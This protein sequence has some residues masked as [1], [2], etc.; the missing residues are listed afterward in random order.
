MR[1]LL[2]GLMI[3]FMASQSAFSQ[4]R[5]LGSFDK[6]RV[7]GGIKVNLIKSSDTK[8]DID[9]E[10]GD[11]DDLITEVK[12][13]VLTIKFKS[14][15]LNWGNNNGKATIDLYFSNLESIDASAGCSI[16]GSD[17]IQAGDMDI[18]VSS[19]STVSV[20][21]EANDLTVD[22][23][24]GATC[25]LSGSTD[26]LEVDVSSGSSFRGR[27]LASRYANVDASSGASA[28]VWATE[29]LVADAS[30]GATIR[31]KGNPK[32]KDIDSGKWSGGSVKQLGGE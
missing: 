15:M 26:E 8:A 31:Y 14:K 5:D 11:Y 3:C 22:V 32:K 20:E 28:T 27:E 21:V 30:S 19:G 4:T 2:M 10:R 16:R 23:S 13:D 29:R 9:M 1:I 12:G 24:S 25:S 6:L 7:S 18:D 17:A